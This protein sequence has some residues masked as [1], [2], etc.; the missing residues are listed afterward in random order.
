MQSI[1]GSSGLEATLLDAEGVDVVP[2][3]FKISSCT[4][5]FE[6]MPLLP[7]PVRRG[8]LSDD[9]RMGVVQNFRTNFRGGNRL[10]HASIGG[11]C[12]AARRNL[13]TQPKGVIL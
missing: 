11:G 3:R 9:L 8:R 6:A 12:I 5:A 10:I 2:P 4:W 13:C 1:L 7:V